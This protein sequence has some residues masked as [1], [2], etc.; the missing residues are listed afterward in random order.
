MKLNLIAVR[1]ESPSRYRFFGGNFVF[2]PVKEEFPRFAF[3][4]GI[5]LVILRYY[6]GNFNSRH[7]VVNYLLFE[8]R[9]P[10]DP[11]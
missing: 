10:L 9:F 6:V 4:S 1:F 2:D 11:A 7:A 5:D 8:W 3:S